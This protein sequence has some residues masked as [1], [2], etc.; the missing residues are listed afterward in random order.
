M[1]SKENKLL[2]ATRNKGK[3]AELLELLS[4][5]P[6]EIMTLSD[7]PDLEEAEETGQTFRENAIEKA[8]QA[9]EYTGLISL[10]DD[11][12]LEV[13][14][15]D[16]QPGVYSARFAGEPKDDDRNNQ[17]LLSLLQNV[18]LARRRARFVSVIAITVPGE[19]GEAQIFSTE[20][21]VEGIILNEL[22]GTGGFGY[23]PLFYIPSLGKTFAE[24]SIEEKNL[25]SHR[26]QALRQAALILRPLLQEGNRE[27]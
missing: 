6:V 15:L 12:G 16:G 21:S 1:S 19:K 2:M 13:E 23:D 11:S 18:P 9:A 8:L 24:L 5:L 26:G 22:R 10:A 17:K 7:F 14:I 25:I 27:V 4:D 20:G 3:A